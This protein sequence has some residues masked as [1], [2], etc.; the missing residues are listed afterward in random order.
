[1]DFSDRYD[2]HLYSFFLSGKEW[3]N[4]SE[5]S[6]PA[7]FQDFRD[8]KK[9]TITFNELHLGFKQKF[10]Y[11]YDYAESVKINVMLINVGIQDKRKKYPHTIRTNAIPQ[12]FFFT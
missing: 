2:G 7:D 8:T 4:D 5:Y 6:G 10:L 9:T 1:M 3:D 12:Q 11:L